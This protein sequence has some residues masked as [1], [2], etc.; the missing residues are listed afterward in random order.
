MV[1]QV[2]S[3]ETLTV[4]MTVVDGPPRPGLRPST[5]RHVFQVIYVLN[6]DDHTVEV[7]ETP[8]IDLDEVLGCLQQGDA[9][10][11]TRKV[12]DE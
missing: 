7:V 1:G 4:S 12:R 8:E 2:N 11:I 5:P 10:F 9:V 3:I 6:D